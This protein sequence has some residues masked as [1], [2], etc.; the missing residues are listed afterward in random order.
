MFF[1]VSSILING[2]HSTHWTSENLLVI[3]DFIFPLTSNPSANPVSFFRNRYPESIS[4]FSIAVFLVL[5]QE[6]TTT[7]NLSKWNRF[8]LSMLASNSFSTWQLE[9]SSFKGLSE[10][11]K[12]SN[13]TYNKTL[14]LCLTKLWRS[15]VWHI[16]CLICLSHTQHFLITLAAFCSLKTRI[17]LQP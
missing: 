1:S 3:L 9:R 12:A 16:S 2:S 11:W 14:N 10:L 13:Y 15:A 17:C 4:H 7:L 5:H 8:S 6:V